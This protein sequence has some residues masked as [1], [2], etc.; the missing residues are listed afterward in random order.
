MIQDVEELRES[1]VSVWLPLLSNVCMCVMYV[2]HSLNSKCD[3]NS[4]A[5]CANKCFEES[6][7]FEMD[8]DQCR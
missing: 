2:V 6:T 4:S 8:H 3:Y 7:S 1:K 5:V